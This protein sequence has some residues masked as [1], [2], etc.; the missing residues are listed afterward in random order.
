M[1]IANILTEELQKHKKSLSIN[2]I[3]QEYDDSI[4][5]YKYSKKYN[6]EIMYKPRTIIWAW[7]YNSI[8]MFYRHRCDE[9]KNVFKYNTIIRPTI[10]RKDVS[11]TYI[12]DTH[13]IF[14]YEYV[15]LS[16][17]NII[18]KIIEMIKQA[19]TK[20]NHVINGNQRS[21]SRNNMSTY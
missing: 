10:F 17:P 7:R 6:K 5:I 14:Q 16:D 21:N 1:N 15:P 3:V 4:L 20:I 18:E 9:I 11:I 13:L 19:V 2:K 8:S 12:Y